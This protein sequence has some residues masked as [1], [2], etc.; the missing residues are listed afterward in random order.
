M[1]RV[2]QFHLVR[3]RIP[4]PL[5]RLWG[6][7]L[8]LAKSTCVGNCWVESHLPT[9]VVNPVCRCS[10]PCTPNNARRSAYLLSYLNLAPHQAF[11]CTRLAEGSRGQEF[12]QN[13]R[14]DDF[15]VLFTVVVREIFPVERAKTLSYFVFYCRRITGFSLLL[16]PC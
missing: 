7:F 11:R 2:P 3:T 10:C 9:P 15:N 14:H 13:V 16:L 8:H 5:F 4:R 6:P 12:S 1:Y